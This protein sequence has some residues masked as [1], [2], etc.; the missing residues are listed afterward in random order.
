MEAET[1]SHKYVDLGQG[2]IAVLER[3]VWRPEDDWDDSWLLMDPRGHYMAHIAP[4]EVGWQYGLIPV[5]AWRGAYNSPEDAVRDLVKMID[6]AEFQT[7]ELYWRGN[8]KPCWR[9]SSMSP[10]L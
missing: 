7:D 8:T 2:R 10:T 9:P 5:G 4:M 3:A 1:E 6:E